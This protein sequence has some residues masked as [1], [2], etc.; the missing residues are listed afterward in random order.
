MDGLDRV[1][2]TVNEVPDKEVARAWDL[3]A[4]LKQLH[5]VVELAVDVAADYYWGV[6]VLYVRLFDQDLF[7][8][9]AEHPEVTLFQAFAGFQQ[10]DP[11]IDVGHY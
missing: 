10:T 2:A 3:A 6:Y 9:V 7:D 8:F 1:V 4:D 11:F 5:K